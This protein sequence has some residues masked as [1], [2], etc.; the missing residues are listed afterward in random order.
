MN[1]VSL[2]TVGGLIALGLLLGSCRTSS[3]LPEISLDR[4]EYQLA[5]PPQ[6]EPLLFQ[7]LQ[8]SQEEILARHGQ[9]RATNVQNQVIM[10]DGNPAISSLGEQR[11]LTAVLVTAGQ[12]Q[13][14][15]TVKLIRGSAIVFETS[16]GLPSPV[17]PL[18]ALWTFDGH[19]A[20]EILFADENTW[21]GE[22]YI[23]ANLVNA[24]NGYDEA[25]GL[26]V[27]KGKPF[28]FFVKDDRVGYSYEGQEIELDYDEIPHYRCCSEG[29]LNPVHAQNMVGF[30]G[31]R[32]ATWFYGELG[33]FSG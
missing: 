21:A 13:P 14:E 26:Q 31:V 9:Q 7:P 5:G 27:I 10:V 33:I 28:F 24:A 2:S 22:V 3:P 23:D 12:G 4:E 20:L 18:Q 15:Q 16:A 19:W 1:R 29:V 30:F 17:L 25:F 32:D 6:V 8:G 11:D